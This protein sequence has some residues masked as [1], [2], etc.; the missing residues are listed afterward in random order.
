MVRTPRNIPVPTALA[1]NAAKWTRRYQA[2][3]ASGTRGDWA[4]PG[5]KRMLCAALRELAHGK[6]VFCESPLEVSGYL[7]VEHYHAK[8]VRSHLAFDWEN[9]LPSC[10]LCNNAKGD[11]DHGGALL[12]PD[13]EDPE[14]YFWIDPD[15]GRLRPRMNLDAEGKRRALETIRICDLQ[16]PALCTKRAD[17]LSRVGRWL[18]LVL[19]KGLSGALLEEWE[20][21]SRPSMEY[22]LVIRFVLD[23]NGQTQLSAHDRSRF[24]SRAPTA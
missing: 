13:M 1:S 4:T 9:L 10:R 11:Q 21:L 8:T 19:D 6:C 7:E 24:T 15:S 12:K 3:L 22:K 18:R 17:M 5:A 23:R 16:R 14:P 20:C 2:V